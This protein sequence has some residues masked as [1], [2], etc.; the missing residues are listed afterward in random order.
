MVVDLITLGCPLD[1]KT[2]TGRTALF[3]ACLV[4]ARDIAR[5]LLDAGAETNLQDVEGS[6]CAHLAAGQGH[7]EVIQLLANYGAFLSLQD[8]EGTGITMHHHDC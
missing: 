6:T 2:L 3:A 5:L 7:P 8:K 1:A 4:N